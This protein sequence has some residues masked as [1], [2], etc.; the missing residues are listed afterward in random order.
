MLQRNDLARAVEGHAVAAQ[1]IA[2][3]VG[4]RT[5]YLDREAFAIG[6]VVVGR[7]RRATGQDDF[8]IAIKIDGVRGG[9]GV[10]RIGQGAIAL[11]IIESK[12]EG[13]DASVS[14]D[15]VVIKYSN[16]FRE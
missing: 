4:E 8:G 15:I 10:G 9:A 3:P 11:I 12:P 1:R 13:K 14:K 5:A 2:G 7:G 16:L 6:A